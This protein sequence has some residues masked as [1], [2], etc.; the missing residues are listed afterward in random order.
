M[1]NMKID[2]VMSTVALT[3]CLML[4]AFIT[5]RCVNM[6][7]AIEKKNSEVNE[8]VKTTDVISGNGNVSFNVSESGL[9]SGFC[10][11]LLREIV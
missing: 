2:N 10:F 8:S 3:V 7:L 11:S 1:K 4:L 5:F 6:Q 9:A